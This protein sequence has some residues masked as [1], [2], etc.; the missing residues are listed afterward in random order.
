[1]LLFGENFYL[2]GALRL[3][4]P[5]IS[6]QMVEIEGPQG[7]STDTIILD[8]SHLKKHFYLPG[9]EATVS[10]VERYRS[11]GTAVAKSMKEV[12][13]LHRLLGIILPAISPGEA[14]RS[15]RLG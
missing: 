1:M 15:Y 11:S 12:R 14:G 9:K 13:N 3:I 2:E 6:F 10:A 5:T 7:D 8:Q 4:L